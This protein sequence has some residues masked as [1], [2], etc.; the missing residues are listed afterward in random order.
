MNQRALR[1][2]LSEA[3][4]SA[5]PGPVAIWHQQKAGKLCRAC[6][7]PLPNPHTS[8]LKYCAHCTGKQL[9][10]FLFYRNGTIWHCRFTSEDQ[11]QILKRV[12]FR[13]AA[14]ICETVKRGNGL[15]TIA[16]QE[17]LQVAIDIG[18]G[19]IV[20]RLCELQYSSLMHSAEHA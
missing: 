14:K 17:N 6:E 2:A 8:G 18:H 15:M 12:V 10:V 9:V 7:T 19:R 20:L 3:I 13:N 11:K 4:A 16:E 1:F 5:R